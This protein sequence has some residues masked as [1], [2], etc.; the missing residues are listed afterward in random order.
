M[1][2]MV[3][4]Y[5]LLIAVTMHAQ[6]K[7]E[8]PNFGEDYYAIAGADSL[9]IHLNEVTILPKQKFSSKIDIRYYLWFKR[10]V[11]RAYPYAILASKRLDSLNARLDRI[12]SSAKK[13]KYIKTVQS[14][15]EKE[16]TGRLK[17]LTRTEGRILLKLIHRQTG[18]TAFDNIKE[19]RS[20]WKAFWYNTTANLFKLS[21]KLAYEPESENEDYLIEDV[22]QRAYVNETLVYQEPKL[23]KDYRKIISEKEGIIDVDV[24]K[25]MFAKR[26]KQSNT[27]KK[28]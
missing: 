8:T 2:K 23:K 14:Y 15:L 19:L 11:Y 28:T 17:K 3:V 20:G 18:K 21:L 1:K 22:I 6:R 10:K 12:S 26:K 27:S 4:I 7:D 25:K 24:Y 13:K 16:L 9:M 5:V